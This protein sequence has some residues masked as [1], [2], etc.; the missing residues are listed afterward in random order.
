[1]PRFGADEATRNELQT[2]LMTARMAPCF[3]LPN[4]AFCCRMRSFE[5]YNPW[6]SP[7]L[8]C[9]YAG[10]LDPRRLHTLQPRMH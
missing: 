10:D 4:N 1:V 5:T 2:L 7:S 8:A 6:R 3:K 9:T